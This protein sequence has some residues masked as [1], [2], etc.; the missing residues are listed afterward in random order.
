LLAV[1][2]EGEAKYFR[3]LLRI[4]TYYP[5]P[6]DILTS[7]NL[8]GVKYISHGDRKAIM[9]LAVQTVGV[10][11]EIYRELIR[12]LAQQ[13]NEAVAKR[14]AITDLI[15]KKVT[16]HPCG[17]ILLSFPC[18]GAISAAT[19]IGVINDIDRWPT[20]KKLKKALGVYSTL[21]QSGSA[22][23][24]GRQG[25]EGSRHARRALFQVIFRCIRSNTA[26][27]DFKD[28][29][30]RQ[31]AGGKP[32]FKAVVSAMGKLA[33]IIYHCLKTG[34]VYQYQGKYR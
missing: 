31:V 18:F 34:E 15:K 25:K 33:E 4:A 11:G 6:E 5:T 19:V 3:K 29:Y 14:Q 10:P 28:Y 23:G 24:K 17:S 13:R 2:P 30:V 1:F 32:K 20:K 22:T 21:R 12:D 8:N 16:C 9:E 26:D 27:N 7:R